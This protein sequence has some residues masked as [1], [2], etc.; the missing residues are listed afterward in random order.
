M[1]KTKYLHRYLQVSTQMAMNNN[2]S[3]MSDINSEIGNLTSAI[4]H[5]ENTLR[6]SF[7]HSTSKPDTQASV[8]YMENISTQ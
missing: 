3:D 5:L 2:P 7:V 4:E 1:Y 8:I 6:Q